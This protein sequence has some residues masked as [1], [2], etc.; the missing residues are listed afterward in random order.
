MCTD[1]ERVT[2][3]LLSD[4]DSWFIFG[5]TAPSHLEYWQT[6]Y[7][8]HTFLVEGKSCRFSFPILFTLQ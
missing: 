4:T 2:N 3:F 6:L 7:P 1:A 8:R 5:V